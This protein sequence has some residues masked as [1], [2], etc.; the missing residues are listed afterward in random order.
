MKNYEISR[1]YARYFNFNHNI[2]TLCSKWKLKKSK[3]SSCGPFSPLSLSPRSPLSPLS[4]KAARS[5]S[6]MRRWGL[7]AATPVPLLRS[8]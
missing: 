1:H 5:G 6:S 8:H 2:S 3:S 4:C 7:D